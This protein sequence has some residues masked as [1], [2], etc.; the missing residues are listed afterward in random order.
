MRLRRKSSSRLPPPA[1]CPTL[2]LLQAAHRW[3]VSGTP[4]DSLFDVGATLRFLRHQPFGHPDWFDA[5]LRPAFND[6]ARLTG[7]RAGA[8]ALPRARMELVD[9]IRHFRAAYASTTMDLRGARM[10]LDAAAAAAEACVEPFA[11]A[12]VARYL[13]ELTAA[14]RVAAREA[15]LRPGS[16]SSARDFNFDRATPAE[17]RLKLPVAERCDLYER[18]LLPLL[19]SV[20]TARALKDAAEEHEATLAAVHPVVA[21][22]GTQFALLGALLRPLFWRNTHARVGA[23][24][25]LPPVYQVRATPPLPPRTLRFRCAPRAAPPQVVLRV[26]PTAGELAM[27]REIETRQ[28]NGEAVR[29]LRAVIGGAAASAAA[30]GRASAAASLTPDDLAAIERAI[31][32]MRGACCNMAAAGDGALGALNIRGALSRTHAASLSDAFAA[33]VAAARRT[34]EDAAMKL[35]RAWAAAAD[36]ATAAARRQPLLLQL[37]ACRH[38]SGAAPV[39]LPAAWLD[40]AA[41]GA[42]ARDRVSRLRDL[43]AMLRAELLPAY[44]RPGE[45][46]AGSKRAA[47]AW[48]PPHPPCDRS[49]A[50]HGVFLAKW[51]SLEAAAAALQERVDGRDE[52]NDWADVSDD[53]VD[54][55]DKVADGGAGGG[56]I[57]TGARDRYR[58]LDRPD[59]ATVGLPGAPAARDKLL[60]AAERFVLWARR[61]TSEEEDRARDAERA[62]LQPLVMQLRYTLSRASVERRLEALWARRGAADAAARAGADEEEDADEDLRCAICLDVPASATHVVLTPC[63]HLFCYACLRGYALSRAGQ[64][65]DAAGGG[66]VPVP[67]EEVRLECPSCKA[68]RK[69]T[70]GDAQAVSSSAAAGAGA[71]G[72]EVGALPLAAFLAEEGDGGGRAALPPDFVPTAR[73]R[74]VPLGGASASHASDAEARSMAGGKLAALIARV[75]SLPRGE[76]ALIATSF[77][78]LR[79]L[80]T[81]VLRREGV[82]AIALEGSPLEMGSA[83]A[84]FQQVTMG[85]E[86]RGPWRGEGGGGGVGGLPAASS[87]KRAELDPR[88]PACCALCDAGRRR[89]RRRPR[90]LD[91]DRLR[92]ADADRG[93]PPLRA[94]PRAGERTMGGERDTRYSSSCWTPCW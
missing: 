61:A 67:A 82:R 71:S 64:R 25:A 3:A 69:F 57:L 37:S 26:E 31:G 62:A 18:S 22:C 74:E 29:R 65:F 46:R 91:R 81:A 80:A 15:A 4:L 54:A 68:P 30:G 7:I 58:S 21:Q 40:A 1:P 42:A 56:V 85:G 84:R 16:L 78:R 53:D 86:G 52:P 72:G 66:V 59:L 83:V 93:E 35:A 24:V 47:A 55:E 36:A 34:L 8:A 5:V 60:G 92:G 20:N 63:A 48:P 38:S 13:G 41:L 44:A 90:H 50:E 94:G 23:A 6:S 2:L 19:C 28:L 45:A 76:K 89:R 12:D 79:S 75:R 33:L 11:P 9:A 73:V 87:V 43:L 10:L 39:H 27:L 32:S 77:S 51:A 70:L 17:Q 49:P 88:S 14:A